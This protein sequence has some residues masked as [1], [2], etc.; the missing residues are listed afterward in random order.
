M[1]IFIKKYLTNIRNISICCT[2]FLQ[3][4]HFVN[5]GCK[6][7]SLQLKKVYIKKNIDVTIFKIISITHNV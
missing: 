7:F 2:V 1:A 3:K 6:H 5:I 4:R